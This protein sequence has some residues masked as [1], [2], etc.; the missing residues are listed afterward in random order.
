MSYSLI[1]EGLEKINT[2]TS[3]SLALI[4]YNHKSRP[5]EYTCYPLNFESNEVLKNTINGMC[6]KF[7]SLINEYE[8]K[9]QD[10]TAT[11]PK[12]V[13]DK[14]S[15]SHEL[16]ASS[17]NS[18]L[19]SLN[20]C[21]DITKLKEIK[22]NAFIFAGTYKEDNTEHNI[23]LMSRRNPIYTYKKNKGIIFESRHNRIQEI[24]EPLVQF[25]KTFDIL[26]YKNTLYTINNNFESIFNMEY[27]HK[28]VCKNS[29]EIIQSA[30]IINNFEAYM[31]FA[32]SGQHPK[33]FITFDRRIIENIKQN[34][35]LKILVEELRIPFNTESQ[36]FDL[37]DEKN[38][39]IFT[40]AICGKTK[41]NMFTAGVCE[42][43]TSIPLVLS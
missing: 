22:S 14:I 1:C 34:N 25:G 18:L 20:V 43:P 23:Y 42:V 21:D 37:S 39:D 7:L 6:L 24:S 30:A 17:W 5:F 10:Y 29:L 15:T 13:V 35:N 8:N 19:Q 2:I 28:I 33:K 41:Y 38:A 40:K 36:K 3:W 31:S 27:S 12:N 16:I 9:V 32:Q 11:N 26:I 4:S